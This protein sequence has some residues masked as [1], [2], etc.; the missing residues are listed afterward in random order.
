[1][2]YTIT[3][4]VVAILFQ[5]SMNSILINHLGIKLDFFT[6]WFLY[7]PVYLLMLAVGRFF[8]YISEDI[9]KKGD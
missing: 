3:T 2:H 9:K 4:L 7:I 6:G 8:Q 1:M 5:L